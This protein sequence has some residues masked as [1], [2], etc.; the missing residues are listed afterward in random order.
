MPSLKPLYYAIPDP[1]AVLPS[2]RK[3]IKRVFNYES[4]SQ[5]DPEM[6]ENLNEIKELKCQPLELN[7]ILG[8]CYE[9][10]FDSYFQDFIEE[11][12]EAMSFPRQPTIENLEGMVHSLLKI[13]FKK[14]NP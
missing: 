14:L 7:D 1:N 6:A 2:D 3:V 5:L 12:F 8:N 9:E 4:I 13:L 10:S 11:V